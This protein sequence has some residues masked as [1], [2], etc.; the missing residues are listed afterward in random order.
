MQ[1]VIIKQIIMIAQFSWMH[2]ETHPNH[3]PFRV[4]VK[5]HHFKKKKF[6][7]C[8]MR[9]IILQTNSIKKELQ[10]DF[11]NIKIEIE[12]EVNQN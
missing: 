4:A 2:V 6:C 5:G 12:I 7:D 8:H 1:L 9:S 11:T 3:P 10:G